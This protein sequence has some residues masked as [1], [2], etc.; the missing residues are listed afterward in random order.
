MHILILEKGNKEIN[1]IVADE[2]VEAFKEGGYDSVRDVTNEGY[3]FEDIL[4][5][6]ANTKENWWYVTELSSFVEA[7]KFANG[8][9]TP[10]GN[11]YADT[12]NRGHQVIVQYF[13]DCSQRVV[14][15]GRE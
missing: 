9:P 11:R 13:S 1:V 7:K 2:M 4:S 6:K 14:G 8:K 12:N 10:Y 3:T 5:G 15:M